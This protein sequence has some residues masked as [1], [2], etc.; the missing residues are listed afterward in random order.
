[1][2]RGIPVAN[3][4][5]AKRIAGRRLDPTGRKPIPTGNEIAVAAVNENFHFAGLV[6]R[7][8]GYGKPIGH[9]GSPLRG[10][11]RLFDQF[12]CA[13]QA[14]R[15]SALRPIRRHVAAIMIGLCALIQF[16]PTEGVTAQ[17]PAAAR[18]IPLA[19]AEFGKGSVLR[20]HGRLPCHGE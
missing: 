11:G 20:F 1:M 6:M 19:G 2:R 10:L 17:I 5:A 9:G 8:G 12:L 14:E 4:L 13:R 3:L 18:A 15:K 16:Q 7:R